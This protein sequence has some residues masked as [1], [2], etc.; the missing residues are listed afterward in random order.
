[1]L[2]KFTYRFLNFNTGVIFLFSLLVTFNWSDSSDPTP[3]IVTSV[4]NLIGQIG[5]LSWMFAIGSKSYK[6]LI[7]KGIE[8]KVFRNFRISYLIMIVV[9]ILLFIMDFVD[10]WTIATESDIERGKAFTYIRI[11]YALGFF[12]LLCSLFILNGTS[13]LLV[14]AENGQEKSFNDYAGTFFLLIF[15]WVGVWFIHPRSKKI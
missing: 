10:P 8:L 11:L 2:E 12:F 6:S 9:L 15:S 3:G 13:K 1:M 4:I 5:L 14:S 7:N